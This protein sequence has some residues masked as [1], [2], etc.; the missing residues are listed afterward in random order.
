MLTSNTG[1]PL[2][3]P[4]YILPG[5][6]PTAEEVASLQKASAERVL[7]WGL[8]IQMLAPLQLLVAP[9]PLLQ[10]GQENSSQVHVEAI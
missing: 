2:L 7:Q 8:E 4:F 5:S 9:Y 6:C 1:L 3:L 10:Q